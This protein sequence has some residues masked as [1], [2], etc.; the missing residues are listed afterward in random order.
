MEEKEDV[1]KCIGKG[2]NDFGVP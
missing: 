1:D 2:M